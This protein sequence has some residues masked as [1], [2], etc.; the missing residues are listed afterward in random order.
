MSSLVVP[1]TSSSLN[2]AKMNILDPF[3]D[4]S[5]NPSSITYVNPGFVPATSYTLF[6]D[7]ST[8]PKLFPSCVTYLEPSQDT[9]FSNGIGIYANDKFFPVENKP[10]TIL[11]VNLRV[12]PYADIISNPIIVSNIDPKVVSDTEPSVDYSEAHSFD[13]EYHQVTSPIPY[14]DYIPS[15]NIRYSPS[16]SIVCKIFI[17]SDLTPGIQLE[18]SLFTKPSPFSVY[19]FYGICF[20]GWQF[21][22]RQFQFQLLF[23]TIYPETSSSSSIDLSD[24]SSATL[25]SAGTQEPSGNP[26]LDLSI[27][28]I[29][30]IHLCPSNGTSSNPGH[31]S[32]IG[33]PPTIV[34]VSSSLPIPIP[35]ISLCI[36]SAPVMCSFFTSSVY[37]TTMVV[38]FNVDI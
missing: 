26:I 32:S 10:H 19:F 18:F 34:L 12:D 8:I 2:V 11:N 35:S 25:D 27:H 17:N 38:H 1:G 24:L 31:A 6:V 16:S 5:I 23:S 15:L 9:K 36:H 30:V 3:F 28:S 13:P 21:W 37:G 7:P 4:P 20:S 33:A 22:L 14:C 29:S